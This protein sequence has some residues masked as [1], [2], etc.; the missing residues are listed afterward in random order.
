MQPDQNSPFLDKSF[1]NA[2]KKK[3]FS[4]ARKILSTKPPKEE[5][6]NFHAQGFLALAET[7]FDTAIEYFKKATLFP[8]CEW[9]PYANLTKLLSSRSQHK[10]AIPFAKKAH[11]L[12]PDDITIG[13]MLVNSMLDSE[14]SEEIVTICDHFLT[15]IPNDV[16]FKLAKAS[17]TRF[18]GNFGQAFLLIDLMAV[19]ALVLML[20]S[21]G[22]SYLRLLA[23]YA[24]FHS[25][26]HQD[27]RFQVQIFQ[28]FFLF[29]SPKS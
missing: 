7:K 16:E 28:L 27:C 4:T 5:W 15:L 14:I 26:Q 29:D 18:F 19:E 13:R 2:V 22:L 17:A 3:D 11:K 20:P 10:E 1:L 23:T 21:M 8:N 6:K 9:E 25:Y 12:K 24:C